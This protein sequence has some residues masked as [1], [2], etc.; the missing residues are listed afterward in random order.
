MDTPY[1][2]NYQ[3]LSEHGKIFVTDLNLLDQTNRAMANQYIAQFVD[4]YLNPS[5]TL[6]DSDRFYIHLYVLNYATSKS[7]FSK[8]L[9]VIQGISS[10]RKGPT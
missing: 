8:V 9:Y 2:T 7:T 5:Q 10:N 6:T 1:F 3:L 4:E